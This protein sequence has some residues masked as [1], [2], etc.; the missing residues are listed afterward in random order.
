MARGLQGSAALPLQEFCRGFST[1]QEEPKSEVETGEKNEVPCETD[2]NP[3]TWHFPENVQKNN[4]DQ[5]NRNFLK[6]NNEPTPILQTMFEPETSSNVSDTNEEQ[7]T[8]P[9]SEEHKSVKPPIQISKNPPKLTK[10][11]WKSMDDESKE[12][13]KTS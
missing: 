10:I 5:Q 2:T 7:L 3:S 12:L 6:P 4:K 8:E 9:E 13:S 1:S 11:V